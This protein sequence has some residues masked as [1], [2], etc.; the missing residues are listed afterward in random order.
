MLGFLERG[1]FKLVQRLGLL[2]AITAFAAT[3]FLGFV[4]YDK[5]SLQASDRIETP[6]IRYADYQNPISAAKVSTDQQVATT[7]TSAVPM[8]DTFTQEFDLAVSQIINQLK[9]LPDDSIDKEGLETNVKILV[10]IKSNPYVKELQLAYAQ[11]LA[12][13]TKH[14][15]NV[16]GKDINVDDFFA[17]HDKEFAKQVDV[18]TQSNIQKMSSLK[19]ERANG[20]IALGMGAA[21]LAVF[22]MLV[23]ML[24]VLRIEKNTRG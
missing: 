19:S 24:V 6:V 1:F 21:A 18:Q 5:L 3:A 23:M 11:S 16:G 2:F 13:L 7:E 20:M 9:Q 17:W 12:K 14:L 22:I 8:Q 10:K 4:A 15:V